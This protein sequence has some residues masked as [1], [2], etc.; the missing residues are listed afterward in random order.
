MDAKP[1]NFIRTS[2]GLVP[3]DL[4]IAQFTSEEMKAA[5]LI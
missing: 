5:G 4:L 1:D 3:I 2:V